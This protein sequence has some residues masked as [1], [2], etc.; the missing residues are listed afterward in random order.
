MS[1][2]LS[3]EKMTS[4][5]YETERIANINRKFGSGMFYYPALIVDA[6]GKRRNALFTASQIR[7]ATERATANP[8]D[9][10]PSIW[11]RVKGWFK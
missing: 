1:S 5:I 11:D 4:R 8:E 9:F 7:E 10:R 2:R 3:G 6:K